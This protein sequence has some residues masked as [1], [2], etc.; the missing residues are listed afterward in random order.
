MVDYREIISTYFTRSHHHTTTDSI[1]WVG[2]NTSTSCDSPAEQERRKEVTFER[3]NEEDR[4][5]RVVHSEVETTIDD[6]TSDGWHETTV[7]TGNT[8]RGESLLVDIDKAVELAFTSLLGTL[9]VVGKAGTGVV[10]RVDEEQR[11]GTSSL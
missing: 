7:E 11:S 10:E 1:E 4:L 6:D 8:V 2:R 9:R 3:T 5:D